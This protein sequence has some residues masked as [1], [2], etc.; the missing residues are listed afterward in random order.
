MA[1][2][3]MFIEHTQCQ[4][5]TCS[6]NIHYVEASHVKYHTPCKCITCSEHKPCESIRNIDNQ[7]FI[8]SCHSTHI[9]T[10][11][12]FSVAW[13]LCY[14]IFHHSRIHAS[15]GGCFCSTHRKGHCRHRKNRCMHKSTQG[16]NR[17]NTSSQACMN[18]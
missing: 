13:S 8:V 16:N 5:I 17:L 11:I 18:I 4:I 14:D 9:E 2:C 1:C 3:T 6:I 15:N 10:C 12:N 7:I